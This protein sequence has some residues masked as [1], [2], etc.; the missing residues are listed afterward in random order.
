MAI[1]AVFGFFGLDASQAQQSGGEG[2]QFEELDFDRQGGGSRYPT[3]DEGA[4][5]LTRAFSGESSTAPE[6]GGNGP[7]K[8]NFQNLQGV[9]SPVQ[10][11]AKAGEAKIERTDRIPAQVKPVGAPYYERWREAEKAWSKDVP[12]YVPP[13]VSL[14]QNRVLYHIHC[15]SGLR[16]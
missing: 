9:P 6:G 14:V 4:D 8:S 2:F 1:L 3:P 5:A 13:C 10:T 7:N 12:N 11:P 16:R 15:A